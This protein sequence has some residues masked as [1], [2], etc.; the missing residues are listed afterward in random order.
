MLF[1][2]SVG[3]KLLYCIKIAIYT[4]AS[5]HQL[6]GYYCN[7]TEF[8]FFSIVIIT[9]IYRHIIILQVTNSDWC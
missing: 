5:T 9:W 8:I 1:D 3:L 4:E 6:Y 2:T 7:A